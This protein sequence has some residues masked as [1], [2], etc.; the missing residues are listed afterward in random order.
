MNPIR[1]RNRACSSAPHIRAICCSFLLTLFVSDLVF[2]RGKAHELVAKAT[3]ALGGEARIRALH[4]LVFLGPVKDGMP[5]RVLTRMR[6]NLR[7]V[8]CRPGICRDWSRIVEGYDGKRGWE[9]NWP[10]QRLIR[11]TN[12]AETALRC[13]AE[14]DPLFV[15]YEQRGF[16]VRHVGL[17]ELFG[18]RYEAIEV[19]P[20]NGCQVQT[21]YLDPQSF[22]PAAWRLR[23]PIHARG[24]LIDTAVIVLEY[25]VVDGVKIPIRIEE[26]DATS[27]ER[28]GGGGWDK[29]IANTISDRS[30]FSPPEVHPGPVTALMLRMLESS[31]QATPT[32]LMAA[33]SAFRATEDGKA[34]DA[35]MDLI[36]L[37]YEFLKMDRFDLAL[38]VFEQIIDEHPLSSN[39]FDSLGDAYL[40]MGKRPEAAAAFERALKL[41]PE[42]KESA[43]KLAKLRLGTEPSN[44]P[45]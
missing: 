32:E 14:F 12:K 21:F 8:G 15:D 33:Y 41:D 44:D 25:R 37:G 34:T 18:K 11:T 2:S 40:Q 36:W 23:M 24:E 39:A 4:S 22:L 3:H 19:D 28:L 16:R 45:R 29:V 42:N 10:K 31:S 38:A 6:P 30:L 35:E 26:R 1:P 13:G 43:R 9:L 7:V 20:Q 5:T 27:G 17:Q